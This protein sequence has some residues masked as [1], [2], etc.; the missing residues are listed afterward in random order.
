M[1]EAA[2]TSSRSVSEKLCIG[3]MPSRTMAADATSSGVWGMGS[4][5]GM[6]APQ[7]KR[8]RETRDVWDYGVQRLSKVRRGIKRKR[9]PPPW[10]PSGVRRAG[11]DGDHAGRDVAH[12]GVEVGVG[13]LDVAH[14]ADCLRG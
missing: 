2:T 6:G 7:S 11:Q 9:T 13:P 8:K 3:C 12:L 14:V 5:C 4:C 1:V 10:L